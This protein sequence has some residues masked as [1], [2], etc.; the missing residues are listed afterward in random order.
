M[1][2]IDDVIE[3][4]RGA[5]E[6]GPDAL[7]AMALSY[8]ATMA[9]GAMRCEVLRGQLRDARAERDEAEREAEALRVKLDAMSERLGAVTLERDALRRQC[10]VTP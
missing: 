8:G 9:L 7:A 10:G 1:T 3:T 5:R 6:D 2:T 4:V